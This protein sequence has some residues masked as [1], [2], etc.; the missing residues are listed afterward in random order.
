MKDRFTKFYENVG[1]YYPEDEIVYSTLSGLIRKKWIIQKLKKMNKGS[2]LDC[3][4]NVGRLSSTWSKG[5]AFGIDISYDV[6]KRGKELYPGLNLIQ[7]DLRELNFLKANSF[8]NAIACEVLEHLEAPLQ[9]LKGLYPL[10]KPG[11]LLL[12]TTPNYTLRQPK[13]VSIGIMRAFGID[14]GV[15]G[16]RYL[17]TAYQPDELAQL[18]KRAGFSVVEK[19]SFEFELR[20]WLKPITLLE[21]IFFNLSKKFF[22]ASKLNPLFYQFLRRTEI[23]L[24]VI[25]DTFGLSRLLKKIFKQGRRS[26]ILVKK[27]YEAKRL[28]L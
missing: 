5:P 20:G 15:D 4:C 17:H 7:A 16:E 27:I 21:K 18:V 19:G 28:S 3:G 13:F 6:L 23:N 11:G 2:L 26:Y 24:F 25:L 14:K 9:F 12:I 8:D 10:L 22:P 1:K